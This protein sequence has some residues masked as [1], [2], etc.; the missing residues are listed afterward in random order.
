M[1]W[2]SRMGCYST[3]IAGWLQTTV[4]MGPDCGNDDNKASVF[5]LARIR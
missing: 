2:D 1:G 5:G 3:K 4:W